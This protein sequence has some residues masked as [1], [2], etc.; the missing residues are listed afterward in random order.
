MSAPPGVRGAEVEAL[1]IMSLAVHVGVGQAALGDA[2]AW[3]LL[4]S[5]ILMGVLEASMPPA[6]A[7]VGMAMMAPALALQ[8][9]KKQQMLSAPAISSR[10]VS[11]PAQDRPCPR[12]WPGRDSGCGGSSS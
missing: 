3:R 7:G 8:V 1:E 9:I 10:K 4:V 2:L 5:G 6:T 12:V 11:G